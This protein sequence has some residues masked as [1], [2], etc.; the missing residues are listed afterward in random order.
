MNERQVIKPKRL[1]AGQKRARRAAEV[2]KFLIQYRRKAHKGWDPNDRSYDREI[3]HK[4]KR[5]N[6]I[7]LD[8][9]IREDED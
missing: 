3:E 6:P 4:V 9:L 1:N 5:M 8:R 2:M 7:L